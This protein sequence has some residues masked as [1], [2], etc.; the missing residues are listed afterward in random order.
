MTIPIRSTAHGRLGRRPRPR[1]ALSCSHAACGRPRPLPALYRRAVRG[2]RDRRLDRERRPRSRRKLGADSAWR[3]RRRGSRGRRRAPRVRERSLA[4]DVGLAQGRAPAQA[5]R[6]HRRERRV[7]RAHRDEGQRQAPGRAPH[8]DAL[9]VELLLLLRRPRGQDGGVGHPLRQAGRLQLHEVRARRR[10]RVHHAVEL[11]A[12]AD[13]PQAR[14]CAGGRQHGGAEA[15]GVHVGVAARIRE[16]RRSRGVSARG[17]QRRHGLRRRDRRRARHPSARRPHRL[18]RRTRG[19]PRDQRKGRAPHEA[20]DHGTRRQVAQHRVRGREPRRSGEGRGRR[21]LRGV[22]AVVRRRFAP[23]RAA[24]DPRCVRREAPCVHRGRSLR[25][26][27]RSGDADRAHLHAAA[28]R[29][30]RALRGDRDEGR[31]AGSRAAASAPPCAVGRRASST[32][33]RSLSTSTTACA[34]PRRKCS[35]RCCR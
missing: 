12:A 16:A 20:R 22:G 34:S 26:P 10:R 32:S 18:H 27:F 7:A 24:V 15:V 8:A 6:P 9:H 19:G 4:R 28:A 1:H 21:H 23:S 14:A 11:A 29:Q 30:D 33:P 13:E 17:G 2:S 5:R 31:G 3:C 35:G 25:A